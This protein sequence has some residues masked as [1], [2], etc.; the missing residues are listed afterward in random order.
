[1]NTS[2]SSLTDNLS[3]INNKEC[4][5]WMERNKTKS[6]CQYTKHKDN[7]LVYKCKKCNYKS[8]KSVYE[9]I[10]KFPNTYQLCNEDLNTFILLLRKGVSPYEYMDTWEKIDENMLPFKES[11]YSKLNLEDITDE[12]YCHAQNVWSVFK[13]KNS[14]EY[15]DLGEYHAQSDALLLSDIFEKFRDTCIEIFKLDP[16]HFLS[17]PRLAWQACLKKTKIK[18]ELQT[19]YNMFLMIESGIRRGIYQSTQRYAK[20]NNK[21]M[22]SYNKD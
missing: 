11:F 10:E 13:I 21:Y 17:P 6:D 9:L 8:Y 15:H 22:K 5:R 3:E 18:L 12:D 19:E 7:R 4:K 20:A 2:L 16:A 1:M 14:R